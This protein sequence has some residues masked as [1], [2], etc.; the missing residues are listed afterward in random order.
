MEAR[1]IMNY[2]EKEPAILPSGNVLRVALSQDSKKSQ[3][4]PDPVIAIA[5]LKKH[6]P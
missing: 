1:K 5:Y 3:L 4:H 2:G 6:V